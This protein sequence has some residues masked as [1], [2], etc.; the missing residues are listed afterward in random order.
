MGLRPPDGAQEGSTEAL[1]G[2]LIACPRGKDGS[3]QVR[4]T[5]DQMRPCKGRGF[6]PA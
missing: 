6:R 1:L 4:S 5:L 3:H 2:P